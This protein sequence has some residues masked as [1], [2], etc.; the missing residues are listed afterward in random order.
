MENVMTKD[1]CEL[2]EREIMETEGG[3]TASHVGVFGSPQQKAESNL[4]N[5]TNYYTGTYTFWDAFF[6]G[7]K[8]DR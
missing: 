1:F 8:I 6:N 4:H 2:N 7:G 5:G 3:A